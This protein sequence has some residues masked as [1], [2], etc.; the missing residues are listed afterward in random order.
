MH[1]RSREHALGRLAARHHGVLSLLQLRELGLSDK[2]IHGRVRSGRLHRLYRGVYAV[3]HTALTPRGRELAAVLACGDEATLSERSAG[4]AWGLVKS[5]PRNVHVICGRS[6]PPGPGIQVHRSRFDERDRVTLDG[7]PVT[8]V[9]RTLV[10]LADVL[11]ETQLADAVNE[12]E[13]TRVFDLA[14]VESARVRAPGRRGRQKLDRVLENWHPHPF[15]RSDAEYLFLA[16]CQ[17]HRLPRPRVNTWI[18]EQEVDFAWPAYNVAVEV[19]GGA[20]HHTRRAFEED[21]RRDRRL[22]VRGIPVLRVTWRDLHA[23]EAELA[24]QLKAVLARRP[25]S[26][27]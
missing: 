9:A 7:V 4:F 10:D 2:A 8:T 6:R 16:F 21:R 17:R 24:A 27:D 12:A 26:F 3:G 20:T 14:Q 25:A 19:D 22:A 15:T 18:G 11:P 1:T 5:R 23:D 13:V